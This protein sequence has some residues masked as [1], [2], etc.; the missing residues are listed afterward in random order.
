M[1]MSNSRT[2]CILPLLFSIVT[3]IKWRVSKVLLASVNFILIIFSSNVYSQTNNGIQI[4]DKTKNEKPVIYEG[5]YLS[6]LDFPIGA[7]GGGVIRMNGKAERR[8]WQCFNNNEEREG[9]GIV[10]NSFFAIRTENNGVVNVKALQTSAIGAFQA[11]KSLTFKGEYPFGCFSFMDDRLPVQVSMEAFNPFIPMDMK[12]SAIPCAIF[13]INV[14]NT[15]QK[16]LKVNLLATQQNAVGFSGYDTISGPNNRNCKGYKGNTNKIVR[17]G[18]RSSLQMTSISKQG[19][20]QLS[21]YANQ[22][23]YAASFTNLEQLYADFYRNGNISGSEIAYSQ[24]INETVD[25]ALDAGFSLKPGEERTIRFVLSWYFPDGDLGKM[26]NTKWSFKGSHYENIW[27]DAANVDAY[28]NNYYAY[29]DSTTRLFHKTLYSSSLPIYMLD[30]M[31]SNLSVLKSPT[32]FW[33]K[34]GY[35]GFWESTSSKEIWNGNCKHVYHYAQGH[36][37]LYPELDRLLRLQDL[38]TITNQ[39]LL[40][41]RDLGIINAL[42]GHFG[43]IL[44]VYRAHL[45]SDNND[46]LRKNWLVTKKAMDY[47]IDTYDSN[48]DGMLSGTYHNTLDCYSSG[49]SPWIGTLYMAALKACE[50]MATIMEEKQTAKFYNKLW[51]DG[52]KNQ[53]NQLWNDSLGYYTEKA[54]FLPDTRVMGNA[55][56]IDMLL[57]QWWSN[58]LNLGQIYPIDHTVNALEKIYTSNRFID[59]GDNYK[60]KYRDFL[61]KGDTGWQMFV[62]PNTPPKNSILYYDEVMSGFEYSAAATMLQY[63]LLKEGSDIVKA[64]SNRYDGRLRSTPEV[65]ASSNSTVFGTGSPFGEDECG[66][67]YGRA[68]SSWSVL[69]AMQGFIYDGP[70]KIIGFKPILNPENHTSFFTTSNSWG[71]FSQKRTKNSQVSAINVEFGNAEIKTIIL[72]VPENKKIKSVSVNLTANNSTIDFSNNQ[73]GD[74]ITIIL[75]SNIHVNAGSSIVVRI[76]Y[77]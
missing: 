1:G 71:L 53:D 33:A 43:A 31:S 45:S 77:N 73:N 60:H 38:K 9:S 24:Q 58:Q 39:G 51:Q 23:S 69:L 40:P 68:L 37:R 70:R 17:E 13:N 7:M 61:G 21:A 20:M 42:D 3:A 46:F 66:N 36:A 44:S 63:G 34:N 5:K 64:I 62:F 35:F 16:Q 11:M 28:I 26:G 14:K 4:V 47:A 8:W 30:R 19:S 25:G 76:N 52:S 22:I 57:G 49:T 32:C 2:L 56:S 74:K 27:S 12:N 48:H 75:Q 29:L 55:I 72:N 54:E 18:L 6:G 15:S 67:Y 41:A 65:S 10:P 59:S 50:Q